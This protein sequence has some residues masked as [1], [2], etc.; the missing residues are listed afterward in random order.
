MG[1]GHEL[2]RDNQF[3]SI[4]WRITRNLMA[5]FEQQALARIISD[6]VSCCMLMA[7]R[8][9]SRRVWLALRSS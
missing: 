7:T 3:G 9:F 4:L 5:D 2:A 6:Q 1:G 8:L